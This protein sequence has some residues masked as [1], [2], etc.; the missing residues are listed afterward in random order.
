MSATIDPFALLSQFANS[1]GYS[2]EVILREILF[3]FYCKSGRFNTAYLRRL[4]NSLEESELKTVYL[5]Y[6]KRINH[7]FPWIPKLSSSQF[8][9]IAIEN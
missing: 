5:Q 7:L 1:H 8:S 2:L 4:V 6:Q 9:S 3:Q